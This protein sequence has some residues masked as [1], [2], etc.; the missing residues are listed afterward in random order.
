MET[1]AR[2]SFTV[3]PFTL[4]EC[5]VGSAKVGRLNQLRRQIQNM[6]ITLYQPDVDEPLLLAEIHAFTGLKLPDCCVL[7]TALELSAPVMTFD[8]KL[9]SAAR[10][11]SIDVAG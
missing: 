1:N 8:D 3:H 9:A 5:L 6:G 10:A 11:R 2:R 7:S 4:A